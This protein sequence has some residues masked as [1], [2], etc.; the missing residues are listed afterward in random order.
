[1]QAARI[2]GISPLAYVARLI[3]EPLAYVVE[4]INRV[5]PKLAVKIL[6]CA[7]ERA[8]FQD[9]FLTSAW[10]TLTSRLDALLVESIVR[11]FT[12][13]DFTMQGVMCGEKPITVYLRFTEEDLLVLSPLIKLLWS[14]FIGGLTSTYDNAKGKNCHPVLLLLDE[15]GSTAVPNLPEYASTVCGRGVSLW[16][17]VQDLSQLDGI[18]G[19]YRAKSLRNNCDTQIYYRPNDDETAERIERRLGRKSDYAQSKTSRGGIETT[20]GQSEQGVPL[21]TARKALRAI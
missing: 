2:E 15:A 3:N 20:Q 5:S 9:K 8:D 7:Y 16:I 21:L 6:E 13:S 12:G 17:A 14:S 10:G 18:Y 4:R 11:S 1:M 19:R